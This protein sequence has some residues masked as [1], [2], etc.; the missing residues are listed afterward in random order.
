MKEFEEFASVVAQ[1]LT[2][3]TAQVGLASEARSTEEYGRRRKDD[4]EDVR[5]A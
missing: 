2:L 4:G 5:S 3:P 1:T